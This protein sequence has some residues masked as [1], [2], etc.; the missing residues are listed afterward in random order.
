[1]TSKIGDCRGVSEVWPQE[2]RQ[3]EASRRRAAGIL[4]GGCDL[5]ESGKFV[6]LEE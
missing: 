4:F 6:V 1:M 5:I 2:S 3:Q